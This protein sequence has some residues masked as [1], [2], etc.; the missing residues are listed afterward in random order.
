[1][2]VF[3]SSELTT[4][5][6][7]SLLRLLTETERRHKEDAILELLL[8]DYGLHE[9][10]W[11]FANEEL[12]LPSSG[13]HS[14]IKRCSLSQLRVFQHN[15]HGVLK[16]RLT[17]IAQTPE[18]RA[19]ALTSF[20]LH[21][22]RC[23]IEEMPQVTVRELARYMALAAYALGDHINGESSEEIQRKRIE[24]AFD[25]ALYGDFPERTSPTSLFITKLLRGGIVGGYCYGRTKDRE[26]PV[27]T[28]R[29]RARIGEIAAPFREQAPDDAILLHSR[30]KHR[31]LEKKWKG[32]SQESIPLKELQAGLCHQSSFPVQD[33]K[34]VF[35]ALKPKGVQWSHIQRM[36]YASFLKRIVRAA[37][38][39]KASHEQDSA[40]H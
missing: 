10:D 34:V 29:L 24:E 5:Q 2:E 33:H 35:E 16:A 17:H 30:A 36:K 26:D 14:L 40:P 18:E 31:P 12:A 19:R 22:T 3:V 32:V 39:V 20:K 11:H 6:H 23:S 1:R 9:N 25:A 21:L 8:T 28:P 15:L 37:Q 13:D 38:G 27:E 4:T 7:R